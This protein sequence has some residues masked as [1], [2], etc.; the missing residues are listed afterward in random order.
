MLFILFS[1]GEEEFNE[2]LKFKKKT[3]QLNSQ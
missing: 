1:R 3:M 2:A